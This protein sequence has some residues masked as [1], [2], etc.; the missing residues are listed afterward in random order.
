MSDTTSKQ[1]TAEYLVFMN[2][3]NGY[4]KAIEQ[5]SNITAPTSKKAAAASMVAEYS[6]TMNKDPNTIKMKEVLNG[7]EQME[8]AYGVKAPEVQAVLS[9]RVADYDLPKGFGGTQDMNALI[10]KGRI[11]A[12]QANMESYAQRGRVNAVGLNG[13]AMEIINERAESTKR[14]LVNHMLHVKSAV[15]ANVDRKVFDKGQGEMLYQRFEK[16]VFTPD[17]KASAN[18]DYSDFVKSNSPRLQSEISAEVD[19]R[20]QEQGKTIQRASS[21][22]I[23]PDAENRAKSFR[24]LE[25]Q[26]A[27]KKHPELTGAYVVLEAM[28]KH[29]EAKGLTPE[30]QNVVVSRAKENLAVSIERGE[31]PEA[32]IRE[33]KQAEQAEVKETELSR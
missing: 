7:R 2:Y 23:S 24:T 30:Q 3:S 31:I 19:K 18:K 1:R 16:A 32:K 11:Y 13:N 9:G 25:P 26:E 17:Q 14:E 10:E 8:K 33:E 22:E 15:A 5:Q 21:K 27:V 6:T 20:Y 28:S 29:A 12:S 4:A